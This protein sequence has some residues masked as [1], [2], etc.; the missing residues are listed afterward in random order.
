MGIEHLG[1]LVPTESIPA[2]MPAG[3]FA[4]ALAGP[5]WRQWPF[6][7]DP[8]MAW[9][10]LYLRSRPRCVHY[11]IFSVLFCNKVSAHWRRNYYSRLIFGKTMKVLVPNLLIFPLS[12]EFY[13]E[14]LSLNC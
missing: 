7:V 5:A 12:F 4:K 2:S 13:A 10:R 6:S 8:Q 9:R 3:T 1:Y 14:V 11:P